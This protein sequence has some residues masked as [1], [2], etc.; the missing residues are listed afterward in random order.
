[1]SAIGLFLLLDTATASIDLTG[2][3]ADWRVRFDPDSTGVLQPRCEVTVTASVSASIVSS[4]P[5]GVHSIVDWVLSAISRSGHLLLDFIAELLTKQ[6]NGILRDAFGRG[7]PVALFRNGLPIIGS[8][9]IGEDDRFL[10]LE[11]RLAAPAG[12]TVAMHSV[13]ARANEEV[14]KDAVRLPAG[15]DKIHYL[16][17]TASENALNLLLGADFVGQRFSATFLDYGT[18]NALGMRAPFPYP[19]GFVHKA[20]LAA[21]SSPRLTLAQ[22]LPLTGAEHGRFTSDLQLALEADADHRYEWTFTLIAPA[23]V[24]IGSVASSVTPKVDL[25]TAITRPLDL[26]LDLSKATVE[27]TGLR[28]TEVVSHTV[29]DTFIDSKGH[30]HTRT[31][32]E[33]EEVDT[34]YAITPP[35]AAPHTALAL[36]AA[37]F[38]LGGLDV[39]R[40]PRKDGCFG[41]TNWSGMPPDPIDILTYRLDGGDPDGDSAQKPAPKAVYAVAEL[42]FVGGWVFHHLSLAGDLIGVLNPDPANLPVQLCVLAGSALDLI[43]DPPPGPTP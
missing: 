28:A 25:S 36:M 10:Y 38:M 33:R 35:T 1:V 26:L 21:T 31:T 5:T 27:V 43:R 19:G 42:G 17:I 13:R 24:V 14:A 32:V 29:T 11:S 37:R 39:I 6:L 34:I 16:S 22:G 12:V 40:S 20:R 3:S 41:D 8:V 7:F 9:V 4:V 15:P 30:P 2:I 23:Q 18:R